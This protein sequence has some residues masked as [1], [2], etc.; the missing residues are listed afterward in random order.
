MD[1]KVKEYSRQRVEE[2]GTLVQN[3][4]Q[5]I[6]G[7]AVVVND[8]AVKAVTGVGTACDDAPGTFADGGGK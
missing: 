4:V 2:A 5:Q 8:A 7:G 1:I 6:D 3:V